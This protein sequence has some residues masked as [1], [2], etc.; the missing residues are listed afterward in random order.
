MQRYFFSVLEK[1]CGTSD[2]AIFLFIDGLDEMEYDGAQRVIIAFIRFLEKPRW[3]KLNLKVC[4]SCRYSP[5]LRDGG[6]AISVDSENAQDIE[7]FVKYHPTI[8]RLGLKREGLQ[9]LIIKR[10]HGSFRWVSSV[11][12]FVSELRRTR[13]PVAA[14]MAEV[15]NFPR[16][17][18]S[19]WEKL[20]A[21]KDMGDEDVESEF[22]GDEKVGFDR[23]S[24]FGGY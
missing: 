24:G 13:V 11:L 3:S 16:E 23:D 7:S 4:I 8:R 21:L 9:N 14:I 5:N 2:R 22:D 20:R 6:L 1:V 19:W 10:A 15:Q 18:D 12:E 17:E